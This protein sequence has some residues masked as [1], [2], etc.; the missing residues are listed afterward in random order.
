[1]T[2]IL[3]A[4]ATT[5][6]QT[7]RIVR[8]IGEI[9]RER[10]AVADIVELKKHGPNP[11]PTRY[12]Q[13]IVAASVHAG[14]YQSG[15]RKWAARHARELNGKPTIFVSVCLGVLEH[16]AKTDA[17]LDEILRKMSSETGW[18]PGQVKVVAGALMYRHYNWLKRWMMRR[19]VAKAHGDVDTSRNYEY[20]DWA[21]LHRFAAGLVPSA[22][23]RER[24]YA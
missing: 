4:Y 20:T 24:A 16:S 13:V 17:A 22:N 1:M 7:E 12:D 11:D 19:I 5:D 15:M 10:R 8:Y 21:D 3:I 18:K 23:D 9:L 6:G 14:G 2:R